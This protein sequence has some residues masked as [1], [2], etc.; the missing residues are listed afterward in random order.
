MAEELRDISGCRKGVPVK[1]AVGA[2][3]CD[4]AVNIMAMLLLEYLK[5]C[6]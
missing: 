6:N 2:V 3:D 1:F 4:G 5:S